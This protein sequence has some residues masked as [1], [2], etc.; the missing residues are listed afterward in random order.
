[1]AELNMGAATW[2]HSPFT[3]RWPTFYYS[4]SFAQFVDCCR[5]F[6]PVI[7]QRTWKP[8]LVKSVLFL[9]FIR[10]H[11]VEWCW[12]IMFYICSKSWLNRMVYTR[13]LNKVREQGRKIGATA[14]SASGVS[15]ACRR[16]DFFFLII[17]RTYISMTTFIGRPK[18][19]CCC[20]FWRP[21]H[22]FTTRIVYS[23]AVAIWPLQ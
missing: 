13:T 11:D 23:R 16:C 1:M 17:E 12:R 9:H 21:N 15:S 7:Y 2:L 4:S 6:L 5:T 19:N 3:Q 18:Q 10:T 20:L 22:M 8:K 14:I